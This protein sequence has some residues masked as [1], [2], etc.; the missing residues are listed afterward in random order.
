MSNIQINDCV[1]K[2]HPVYNLYASDEN[3]NI[4]HVVKQ[5]PYTGNKQKKWLFMSYGK[6]TWTKWTKGL[7][8]S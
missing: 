8:R 1:Y 6:K 2:V 3:G 7:L 5:V 4:I